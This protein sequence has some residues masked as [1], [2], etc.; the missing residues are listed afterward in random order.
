MKINESPLCNS[1]LSK[2]SCRIVRCASA[3]W[4]AAIKSAVMRL[5]GLFSDEGILELGADTQKET[6][7]K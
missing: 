6:L 1:M 2:L 3:E 5:N 7:T 4:A